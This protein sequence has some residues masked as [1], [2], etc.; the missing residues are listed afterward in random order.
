MDGHVDIGRVGV[1][2]LAEDQTRLAM[3]LL[4]LAD[5]PDERRE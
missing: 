5:E 2:I 3:R 4:A 1:E